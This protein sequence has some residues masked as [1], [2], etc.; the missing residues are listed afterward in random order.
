ML[1][2]LRKVEGA[3]NLHL[4]PKFPDLATKGPIEYFLRFATA[5]L[6]AED[7]DQLTARVVNRLTHGLM[8]LDAAI[9]ALGGDAIGGKLGGMR[10]MDSRIVSLDSIANPPENGPAGAMNELEEREG[11]LHKALLDVDRRLD[12]AVE[13]AV[14]RALE[15]RDLG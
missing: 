13:E 9:V 6:L 2:K 11:A 4:V 8:D 15:E 3:W 7:A 10:F 1:P 14:A 5:E 12:Q